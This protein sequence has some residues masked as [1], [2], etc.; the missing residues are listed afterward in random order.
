MLK[1]IACLLALT[2][3]ALFTWWVL[4]FM[5][6]GALTP[7]DELLATIGPALQSESREPAVWCLLPS[8]PTLQ[9][10]VQ[11]L[12]D[13]PTFFA[14]FWN[15]C[16]LAFPQVAGQL[17]VAAPAAWAFS[18]LEFPGRR[19]LYGAYLVLMVLPFQITMVPNYLV[20]DRLGLMDTPWAVI[21]PGVFSAFPV[22]II[23]KG[24]DAVPQSLLEAAALDGAGPLRCFVSV[25]LPLGLPAVLSA[26]TLGFIEAWNAIEQPMLFLKDKA[27]WPLSLYL[28]NITAGDLG[29]AMVASLM[30]LA[31]PLLLFLTGRKYLEQG[32][33]LAASINEGM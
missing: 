19:V 6:M 15:A 4:W 3:L 29:L 12:L 25:G 2:L 21:L 30:M 24:F 33:G 23:K 28:S 5:G 16:K 22:F 32:I 13:T 17:V 8:W 20:L 18:K 14:M 11:L 9:P 26:A 10:L 1:R 7:E 27:N 31:P